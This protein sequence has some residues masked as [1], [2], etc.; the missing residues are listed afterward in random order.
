MISKG[1]NNNKKIFQMSWVK[2]HAT[3]NTAHETVVDR[4]INCGHH[5]EIKTTITME[6]GEGNYNT[7]PI[8]K[9]CYNS[10]RPVRQVQAG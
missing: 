8:C 6:F 3:L 10:Y 4:C 2:P 7:G 5:Q 9:P 1:K